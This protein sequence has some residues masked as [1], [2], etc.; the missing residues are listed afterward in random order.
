MKFPVEEETVDREKNNCNLSSRIVAG[1]ATTTTVA[2]QNA[3][4]I[5]DGGADHCA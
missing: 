2:I 4:G 5:G 1:T 3:G